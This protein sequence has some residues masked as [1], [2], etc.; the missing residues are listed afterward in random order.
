M[1][2]WKPCRVLSLLKATP[3]QPRWAT[4]LLMSPHRASASAEVGPE[5]VLQDVPTFP[6]VGQERSLPAA[7]EGISSEVWLAF[8]AM[9]DVKLIPVT[10]SF[11]KLSHAVAELQEFAVHKS[12]LA[13]TNLNVQTVADSVSTV[14]I[15]V[16]DHAQRLEKIEEQMRKLKFISDDSPKR[17]VFLGLPKITIEERVGALQA[18]MSAHFPKNYAL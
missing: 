17:F 18:F 10:Q 12:E 13:V 14:L 6:I 5:Q 3:S 7:P 1:F 9:F 8:S 2:C 11:S 4:Q 16:V 15:A